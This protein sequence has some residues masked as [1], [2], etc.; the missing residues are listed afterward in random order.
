MTAATARPATASTTEAK[1]QEPPQ[2][3]SAQ[4]AARRPGTANQLPK[5]DTGR[6]RPAGHPRALL[7]DAGSSRWATFDRWPLASLERSGRMSRAGGRQTWASRPPRARPAGSPQPATRTRPEPAA[8]RRG[9]SSVI[10]LAVEPRGPG[11]KGSSRRPCRMVRLSRR[12]QRV[13]ERGENHR[14]ESRREGAPS[15]S[16]AGL[17]TA[18]W[19][20]QQNPISKEATR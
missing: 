18:C 17:T 19:T 9:G 11:L 10:D 12:Y 20:S 13:G 5:M 15:A 4:E 7:E 14:E 3:E 16:G 6:L 1:P 2:G 8:Y